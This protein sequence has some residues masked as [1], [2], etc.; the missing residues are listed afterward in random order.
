MWG[1]RSPRGPEVDAEWLTVL[2]ADGALDRQHVAA[3]HA[4]WEDRGRPLAAADRHLHPQGT[5]ATTRSGGQVADVLRCLGRQANEG[6]T[7]GAPGIPYPQL[8]I[9]NHNHEL[10]LTDGADSP[11]VTMAM[12]AVIVPIAARR[13]SNALSCR[14][15]YPARHCRSPGAALHAQTRKSTPV[16]H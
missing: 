2:A 1:W 5:K 15:A 3:T 6:P 14:T 11:W 7:V 13:T 12:D 9:E 16:V 8:G 4:V 10:S